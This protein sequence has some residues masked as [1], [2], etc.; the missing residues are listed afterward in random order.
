MVALDQYHGSEP[1]H[2]SISSG[3]ELQVLPT[4][5]EDSSC[6]S[7]PTPPQ[8]T[9]NVST[10]ESSSETFQ[11]PTPC[12]NDVGA[13]FIPDKSISQSSRVVGGLSGA[14]RYHLLYHHVQPSKVLPSTYFHGCN[15]K[16]TF[17]W[18]EKYPCLRYSPS[19]DGVYCGPCAVLLS[20]DSRRGKQSLVNKPLSNWVKISSVVSSHFKLAY[21]C[22]AAQ[23]ADVLKSS[24]DNPG[25][26]IDVMTSPA[27][28]AHIG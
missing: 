27:L 8:F 6:N 20:E 25:T 11:G 23:A 12:Y 17:A 1:D 4:C 2:P 15:R 19:Q 26:R 14:E 9:P 3:S 28:Q 7:P 24:L 10:S 16:F 22:D 5:S 13:L 21:Y 18:L